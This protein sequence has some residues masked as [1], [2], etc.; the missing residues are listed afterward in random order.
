[1]SAQ[2]L[3]PPVVAVGDA[4]KATPAAGS[5]TL[6]WRVVLIAEGLSADAKDDPGHVGV[7]GALQFDA[8]RAVSNPAHR[9]KGNA[10]PMST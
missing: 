5:L 7:Q 10:Q 3:L 9:G 1:M 4:Q 2:V 8:H 6:D